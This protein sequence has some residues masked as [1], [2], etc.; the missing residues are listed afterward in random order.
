MKR[1]LLLVA[2]IATPSIVHAQE[3]N[4]PRAEILREQ[5]ALRQE[6][7][8]Q[9][10]QQPKEQLPGQPVARQRLEQQ[11]RQQ[12]WRAAKNR[13]GFTDDQM[14]KLEQTSIRF[15]QRRRA[16]AQE[17][18]TQ[19][20]AMRAGIQADTA[21]NQ[22]SIASALDQLQQIQHRRA[23]MLADEQ[24]EYASFMTPLQRAKLFGLQEQIRKRMQEIVKARPDSAAAAP[25]AP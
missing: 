15:Y 17:E 23:D 3:I 14:R 1:H 5:R 9:K 25:P 13:I 7:K 8:A 11:V 4:R 12:F 24:K 18:R 20:L 21:A 10:A 19:R 2:L 6:Q 22:A 16:L